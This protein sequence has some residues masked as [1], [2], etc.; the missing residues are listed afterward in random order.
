VAERAF[1]QEGPPIV[2]AHRGACAE[3]P[4][5]TLSSFDRA[6]ELGAEAVEFD[7]RLTSDGVAVVMHDADVDRTTD[8]SGAVA[9]LTA[10]DVKR[11]R[12]DRSHEVPT[13]E[14]AL[15]LLSGRCAVDVE[16]KNL[17]GEQGFDA[18]REGAVE[19]TL[20]ALDE[21]AFVGPVLLSSFNPASIRR[22]RELAPDVPTGL[23][24]GFEV[25][26]WTAL[27]RARD[28][29]HPW[30][31]PFAG[32]VAAAGPALIEDV[33][34]AGLRIG[35]WIA[36]DPVFAVALMRTGVDAV[37][38]NDPAAILAARRAEFAS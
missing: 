18:D 33:R 13:L 9:D 11:L 7:V 23:L 27:A 26:G 17:P 20:R 25:E 10:A 2:V 16:I 28:D 5:N 36:D 4:E 14:E 22:A 15:R 34:A 24:T 29:G 30:M 6:A 37:A 3:R 32:M 8:G 19:A 31:L 1:S 35:T 38:T 12:I 21:V